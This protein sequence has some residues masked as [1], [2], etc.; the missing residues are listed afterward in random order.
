MLRKTRFKSLR[1]R[2]AMSQGEAERMKW[3]KLAKKLSND[4]R[5][6]RGRL[7]ASLAIEKW[8][9]RKRER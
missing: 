4:N 7:E 3:D 2:K 9:Q 6:L 1:M 8:K 5:T